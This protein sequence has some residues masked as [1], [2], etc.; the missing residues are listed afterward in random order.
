MK[1]ILISTFINAIAL[2]AAA[3]ILGGGDVAK[4]DSI[5]GWLFLAVIFGLVNTFV[6]PI[7]KLFSLPFT[8]ITLGL[9]TLVINAAMLMLTM[10]IAGMLDFGGGFLS[11]VGVAWQIFLAAIII[12]VVSALLSWILPDGD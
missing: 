2:W 1:K 9:F 6:K 8:V 4:Q 12:S 10:W 11:G 7:V 3:W 5:L